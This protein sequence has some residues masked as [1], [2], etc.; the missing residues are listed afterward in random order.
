MSDNATERTKTTKK[1]TPPTSVGETS[2]LN[3]KEIDKFTQ[4]IKKLS[5]FDLDKN[6]MKKNK[7]PF[8]KKVKYKSACAKYKGQTQIVNRTKLKQN[9]SFLKL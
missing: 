8:K 9:G 6:K 1:L 5:P 7:Q 4:I 3:K 2:K